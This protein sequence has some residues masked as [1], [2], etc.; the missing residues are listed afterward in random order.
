[1]YGHVE[2][3]KILI[4]AGADIN[5]PDEGGTSVDNLSNLLGVTPILIAGQ[6]YFV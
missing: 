2:V 6:D 4:E 5:T 3:V 1:M